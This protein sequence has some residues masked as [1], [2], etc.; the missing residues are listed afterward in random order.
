MRL[1]IAVDF[2]NDTKQ[3]ICDL[4]R[5]LRKH[6]TK[7]RWKYIDN[8]H[9]TLKFLGEVKPYKIDLLGQSIKKAADLAVPFVV[10]INEL[11]RFDGKDA[12]RAL[13]LGVEGGTDRLRTLAE[14]IDTQLSIIGFEKEK[15]AYTP[16]VTIAQDVIF[17]TDF[18]NIKNIIDKFN[19]DEM[20][21]NKIVLMKSEQIE[22]KRIY[23]PVKEYLLGEGK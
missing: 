21:I 13:W 7:G 9:L 8:F 23:T 18:A 20:Y 16:H 2:D 15:R 12:I 5:E 14:K 17:D 6:S 3:K 22:N 19:F 10:K 11:G 1:F 4:Q